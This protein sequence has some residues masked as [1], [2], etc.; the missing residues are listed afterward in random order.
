MPG[1]HL[2][3]AYAPEVAAVVAQMRVDGKTNEHKAALELLGVLPLRVRSSR[4]TPPSR[5][6]TS[7]RRSAPAAGTTSCPSRT[8]S[9]SWADVEAAFAVPTALSP[10]SGGSVT[11]ACGSP[12]RSAR[13]TAA[14]RSGCAA[15]TWLNDYPDW[16][17]VAQVFLLRRERTVGHE[18]TVEEVLGVTS[19]S[20][21]EASAA[22]L[23]AWSAGTGRSRISSSARDVTLAEDA[24]QVRKGAAAEV[25]GGR[26]TPPSTCSRGQGYRAAALRHFMVHPL[27]AL[28]LMTTTRRE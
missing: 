7:A 12:V 23:L 21:Q 28:A 14:A 19:P 5:T 9:H 18:T 11:R 2:L 6:A 20:P 4:P 15:T 22:Q 27:E 16:P 13:G 1:V 26:A 10:G 24:C 8:T 17:G 3:T 25:L